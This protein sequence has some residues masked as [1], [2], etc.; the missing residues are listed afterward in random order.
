VDWGGFEL[1]H[2]WRGLELVNEWRY[3]C[4]SFFAAFLPFFFFRGTRFQGASLAGEKLYESKS[5]Q[6]SSLRQ[7]LAKRFVKRK[8]FDKPEDGQVPSVWQHEKLE[9]CN[10][11]YSYWGDSALLLQRLWFAFFRAI[12]SILENPFSFLSIQ[13]GG[14]LVEA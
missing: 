4:Y 6:L 5:G 2:A 12:N 3:R 7:N 8:K 14:F 11:P 13:L 1:P 9:R 10:T